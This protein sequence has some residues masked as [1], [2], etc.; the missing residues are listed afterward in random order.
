MHLLQNIMVSTHIWLIHMTY[1]KG[2]RK[3]C[4]MRC[5]QS[6]RR[7]TTSWVINR[8]CG[9]V[10]SRICLL[11]VPTCS[12]DTNMVV[13]WDWH[14]NQPAGPWHRWK[15][16]RETKWGRTTHKEE[17]KS[18][19]KSDAQ[20]REKLKTTLTTVIDPLDTTSHSVGFI[21]IANGLVSHNNGNVDNLKDI[22]KQQI[23]ELESGWPHEEECNHN[24][25]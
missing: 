12:M 15:T 17:T 9:T 14:C 24:G 18:R 8:D 7:V 1:H 6:T 21:N 2:P 16:V 4:Q 22:G 11:K 10:F 13:Y 19:I 23:N 25:C 20:D 3:P 5:Y